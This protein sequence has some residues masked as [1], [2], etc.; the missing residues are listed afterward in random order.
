MVDAARS[1]GLASAPV[2][3][4]TNGYVLRSLT[5]ADVT[6]RFVEWLNGPG[7]LAGLNLAALNFDL[8]G[9][10]R[11]VAGFDGLHNHFI[12]IFDRENGLLVGFYTIDVDLTHKVGN[13]T[14]GIG[15]TAYHG[16]GVLLATIDALLDH[17]YA[18][19][20]VEKM[21]ARILARNVRMI[22]NFQNDARFKFEAKLRRE[23]RATDGTRLDVLIFASHKDG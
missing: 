10:R 16:R 15:E 17:F 11:F 22:F 1:T 23:C 20:D 21:T 13:I 5:P 14:T 9:L 4:E 7:M 18:Y 19:R 12:G 6:P 3:I 8:E 2:H